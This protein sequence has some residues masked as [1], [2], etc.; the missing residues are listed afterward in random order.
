MNLVRDVLD[1]QIVDRH[2]DRMGKVDGLLVA[3]TPG[4][5]P[6]VVALAVGPVT[7][8]RRWSQGLAAWI[9]RFVRLLTSD[10]DGET[11]FAVAAVRHVDVEVMLDV[12]ADATGAR[13]IEHWLR[14][15]LVDRI[16]GSGAKG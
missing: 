4:Q 9:G 10:H 13:R 7:A 6:R 14:E 8:A 5:A 1:K 16:P 15:H 11:Q 2:S 12:E 3:V